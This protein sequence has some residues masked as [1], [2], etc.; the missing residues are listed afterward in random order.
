MLFSWLLA[1]RHGG[2]F[3]FRIEDT[4]RTRLVPDSIQ[5]M[6]Q[7]FAWLGLDVDEGP[8]TTELND[9][10]YGWD[11][12]N[13]FAPGPAPFIQSLRLPRYREV[14]EQLI[15]AGHAYRCDCTSERLE[16]ERLAQ[17][18]RSE[19]PGYSGFCRTRNVPADVPHVVRFRIPD[20]ATVTFNDAI[21]GPIVWDPVILR[22]MVI[23]KTDGYPTYHLSSTVDDHDMAISHVLRG[24]EWISTTPLHVLLY[25]ALGWEAPAIAHLPVIVGND[26]K[27]LSKRHG[28]TFV[29]NFRDEGYLP[30]ALLNYLL[31]N[32]WSA[33]GG[34]EQEILTRDEMIARFSL[35]GVHAAPATF[36]YDKL[37]WMN[38]VYM[39]NT[40]DEAL[41]A[42]IM[43]F[44]L[45]AGLQADRDQVRKMIPYI[46]ERMTTTLK[47]AVPLLEFLFVEPI[48]FGPAQAADLKVKDEDARR[49]LATTHAALAPLQAFEPADVEAALHGLPE[50]A[51]ASKKAAFMTVRVAI[52]GR[53]ATPPLFECIAVLGKPRAIERIDRAL[54]ALP[55]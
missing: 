1:R 15:A 28:A 38:G 42:L 9:A 55:A 27:K 48:P 29:R 54:A 37:A 52:T 35:G 8:T 49:I 44:L 22:D 14:A 6:V 53:K 3:C 43:P 21:R 47:D 10:G 50:A 23:L 18:A 12:G 7:D 11:G 25:R 20:G 4:D 40:P 2:A 51:G 39:R 19:P 31:L 41:T 36:S 16:A 26:G 30:D 34:D 5:S 46:R 32:G 17:Q 45:Q 13:G 33:G 24:E